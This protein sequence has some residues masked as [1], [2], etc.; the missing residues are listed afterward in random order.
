MF[1]EQGKTELHPP[2]ESTKVEEKLSQAVGE[3]R[4]SQPASSSKNLEDHEMQQESSFEEN[5]SGTSHHLE[6]QHSMMKG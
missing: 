5:L 4:E 1:R 2:T 6:N 3:G